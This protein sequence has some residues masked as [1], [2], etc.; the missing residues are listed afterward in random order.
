VARALLP[1]TH[2]RKQG[3]FLQAH[4]RGFCTEHCKYPLSSLVGSC[5]CCALLNCACANLENI[6]WFVAGYV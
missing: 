5:S 6:F 1:E 4:D 3:P 2:G